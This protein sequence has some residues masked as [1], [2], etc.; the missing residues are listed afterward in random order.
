MGGADT[1]GVVVAIVM[2]VVYSWWSW[3][4]GGIRCGISG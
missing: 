3:W 1:G 2:E 4:F